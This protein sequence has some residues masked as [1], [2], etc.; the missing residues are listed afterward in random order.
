LL[1]FFKFCQDACKNSPRKVL[2]KVNP[3]HLSI[4]KAK[5][6][7]MGICSIETVKLWFGSLMNTFH[8]NIGW[9][10]IMSNGGS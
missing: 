5:A 6:T 1:F 8:S 4:V 2:E 10:P 9:M 3:W 7:T